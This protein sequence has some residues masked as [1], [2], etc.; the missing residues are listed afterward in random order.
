MLQVC[1]DESWNACWAGGGSAGW[2]TISNTASG[3]SWTHAPK[4]P[5]A[6]RTSCANPDPSPAVTIRRMAKLN[7]SRLTDRLL[8]G[9]MP[10]AAEHVGQ[11]D[12]EGVRHV[13]NLCE[14]R[15]YWE[16]ERTTVLD[17]YHAF[18]I[19]EHHLPVKDGSTVPAAVIDAAVTASGD[20]AVYVHC[21]GGRE[22]SAT[23][24]AALLFA[25]EGISI[26]LAI[27][28]SQE[29]RPIFQPLPWQVAALRA[30]A[31]G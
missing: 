2:P 13:I 12:G 8:A 31:A 28:R 23:V 11:L 15:E 26:E 16:D 24:A 27:R 19:V 10:H 20:G 30:W 4:P 29:L 25:S 17:A 5:L 22:R 1:D 14:E 18:G 21:R 3:R 6:W 7:Y 9:A